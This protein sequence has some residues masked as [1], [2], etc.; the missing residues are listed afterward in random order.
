M[1][2]YKGC[3]A[4]YFGFFGL[5]FKV[6][7]GLVWFRRGGVNIW[8]ESTAAQLMLS[9]CGEDGKKFLPCCSAEWR[10]ILLY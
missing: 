1:L 7:S 8:V 5:P 3:W 2:F 10:C 4:L 6:A 9:N